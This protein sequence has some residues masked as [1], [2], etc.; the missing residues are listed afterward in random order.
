[1]HSEYE[2]AKKSTGFGAERKAKKALAAANEYH[3]QHR[4][5]LAQFANAEKYLRDV[6]QTH[7]DTKKLPPIS[8]WQNELSVKTAEKD[9]LY[10]DYYNLKDEAHNV[11]KIKAS[12]KAILHND[13]PKQVRQKLWDV[14]L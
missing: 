1:M 4:S 10:R 13:T 2:A 7:F 5:E 14:E 11:G 9:A 6:L 3:E 8:K 12:V